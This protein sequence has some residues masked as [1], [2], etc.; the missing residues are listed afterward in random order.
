MSDS[1]PL[2]TAILETSP[3][4]SGINY[5]MR[6]L[7][8]LLLV[9]T[10]ALAQDAVIKDGPPKSKADVERIVREYLLQ[11]PE[12]VIEAV[13]KYQENQRNDEK[14]KAQQSISTNQKQLVSDPASPAAGATASDAVTV[15]EFF[16]YRC[17]YCKR[18]APTISKFVAG[19]KVRMV[20]KELPIL[21]PDSSI[22]AKA[23]LGARK[24]GA[25][26]VKVHQDLMAAEG[27]ITMASIEKVAVKHGLDMA[28]LKVDMEAP[29]IQAQL[30]ANQALANTIGVNATPSFV[31]GNEL[32]TGAMDEQELQSAI[33]KAQK[34]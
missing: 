10:L 25:D 21:G 20:Y 2:I 29:E 24:Q 4:C 15:V 13:S 30:T 33:A 6:I 23:A 9:A 34:H 31:I 11:H 32:F 12:I 17:G 14:K 26:Y 5:F 1:G 8:A 27:T 28:K 16:D 22:A 19:A 7:S 3:I 18:M